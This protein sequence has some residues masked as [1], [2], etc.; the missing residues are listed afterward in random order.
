MSEGIGLAR[1][2]PASLD[3]LELSR[4]LVERTLELVNIPSRS[5]EEEEIL[6]RLEG[7]VPDRNWSVV[8]R[9]G[10]LPSGRNAHPRRL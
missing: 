2:G 1:V 7:A 5:R 8:C 10:R 6:R 9:G 4:R 3:R